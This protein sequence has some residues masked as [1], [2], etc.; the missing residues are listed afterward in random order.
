MQKSI[1][2][3]ILRE[4]KTTNM[5]K[6]ILL[7]GFLIPSLAI[8][9]QWTQVGNDIDGQA[10]GDG[11]GWGVS[12]SDDGNILATGAPY[13]DG[14]GD[15]AG[16][17]FLYQNM[18]GTWAQIGQPI[19][20]TADGDGLGRALALNADGSIVAVGAQFHNSW[21]GI[22]RVYQNQNGSWTQIGQDLEGDEEGDI[23]G[24]AISLSDDGT[25]MAVGALYNST[26]GAFSGQVRIFQNINGSWVQMGSD[27]LGDVENDFFGYAISLNSDGSILGVSAPINVSNGSTNMAYTRVYQNMGGSWM[28]IGQDI[29]GSSFNDQ[30]GASISISAN[31]S[32]LALGAPNADGGNG[33]FSGELRIYEYDN[34]TWSQ[35]GQAIPGEVT[36]D[37]FG[38]ATSLNADGTIVAAGATASDDN[39]SD[40]GHV[41]VFKNNNGAW[42]QIGH[43]IVGEAVD[44]RFGVSVGLSADGAVLAAGAIDNDGNG[45]EAGHVRVFHGIISGVEDYL[46]DD[47]KLSVFPNPTTGV[48][49]LQTVSGTVGQVSIMDAAGSLLYAQ[50]NSKQ[51]SQV[52]IDLSAFAN[53]IYFVR[54]QTEENIHIVKIV[55]Q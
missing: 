28:Q 35:I 34:G 52:S 23:F 14:G 55:K 21:K 2:L 24:S 39:G 22:V 27:L 43:N 12:L 16:A 13:N 26:N 19:L 7:L 40:S 18:N 44:D 38:S 4:K 29:M 15:N 50:R 5:K 47:P 30:M 17:V 41:R 45:D 42:V 20:G 33:N 53:G 25:I 36:L 46:V 37:F 8:Q 48:V 9:A 11:L 31:G 51:A 54:V 32:T 49:Q 10:P 3:I 1:F 6:I